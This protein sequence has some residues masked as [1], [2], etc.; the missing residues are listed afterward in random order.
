M[1]AHHDTWVLV[2]SSDAANRATLR[3]PLDGAGYHVLEARGVA[4][5]LRELRR[6][7]HPLTVLL[8]GLMLPLLNAVLPDRRTAQH[9]AYLL[10]CA[11][12]DECHP[13]A[14]AL[15]DQLALEVLTYPGDTNTLLAAVERVGRHLSAAPLYTR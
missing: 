13:R 8:D 6:S 9:H 4:E 1:P 3:A 7:V 2:I 14:Q 15:L 11:Q 5:A 12:N 10:L